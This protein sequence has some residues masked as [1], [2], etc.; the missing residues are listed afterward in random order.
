[1]KNSTAVWI[2][3]L[4]SVL[5]SAEAVSVDRFFKDGKIRP[6]TMTFFFGAF[7]ALYALPGLILEVKSGAT[8]LP[9]GKEWIFLLCIALFSFLADYSHFVA[10]VQHRAGGFMVALF[11]MTMPLFAA[12][13]QGRVPA[14]KEFLA[15]LLFAGGTF[16]M[17]DHLKE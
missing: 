15:W 16:L 2:C 8:R 4:A 7:I 3:L 14:S 6:I 17:Y 10:L 9:M 12:V 13:M 11:Y 5:Y 1:M